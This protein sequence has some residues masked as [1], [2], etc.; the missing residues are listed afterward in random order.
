MKLT[1]RLL[2]HRPGN[3]VTDFG[4]CAVPT[5][6]ESRVSGATRM[7]SCSSGM[8]KL[9]VWAVADPSIIRSDGSQ[10]KWPAIRVRRQDTR[11]PIIAP[12]RLSK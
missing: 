12:T 9:V 10:G 8:A 1:C 11:E 7:K 4:N 5:S 6:Q 3:L 2:G